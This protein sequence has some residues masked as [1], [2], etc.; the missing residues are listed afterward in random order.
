MFTGSSSKGRVVDT[1]FGVILTSLSLVLTLSLLIGCLPVQ[2]LLVKNEPA[3]EQL[4]RA[5]QY[6]AI[7]Y[8]EQRQVLSAQTV[9]SAKELWLGGDLLKWCLSPD[10]TS[11]AVLLQSTPDS[12][13]LSI[14]SVDSLTLRELYRFEGK[15]RVDKPT[16]E[17]VAFSF[18]WNNSS[19]VVA[20]GVIPIRVS[21]RSSSE[22]KG[23]LVLVGVDGVVS[24][25]GCRVS[26]AVL[27]WLPNDNLVVGTGRNPNVAYIVDEH[28]CSDVANISLRGI[29]ELAFRSKYLK[30]VFTYGNKLSFSP[31]G[32]YVF[33]YKQIDVYDQYGKVEKNN[34]LYIANWDG[35]GSKKIADYKYDPHSAVWSPDGQYIAMT[36]ESQQWLATSHIACYDL[37]TGQATIYSQPDEIG[38]PACYSPSWS[39][40]SRKIAYRTVYSTIIS[41]SAMPIIEVF[42]Q[43]RDIQN[44][45]IDWAGSGGSVLKPG[46]IDSETLV[47]KS[48]AEHFRL[49]N[50]FDNSDSYIMRHDGLIYVGHLDN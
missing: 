50:T 31:D 16:G 13:S 29:A 30:M 27:D 3:S 15:G 40:D 4:N 32:K 7:T 25:P 36:V 26:D 14:V 1:Y 42:I 33:Y 45:D 18:E 44:N 49:H 37:R 11:I 5:E 35:S 39:P 47:L 28:D 38:M 20:L 34:E 48:G 2:T 19:D 8:I 10:S 43:I 12:I 6:Y 24:N 17:Y 23:N 21:N 41:N 9:S 46:W 22:R